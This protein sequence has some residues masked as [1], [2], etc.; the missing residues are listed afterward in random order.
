MKILLIRASIPYMNPI[1]LTASGCSIMRESEQNLVPEHWVSV[2][3]AS[4]TELDIPSNFVCWE[5]E[6]NSNPSVG[7]MRKE[8]K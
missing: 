6:W 3:L 8:D 4:V 7:T 1:A 2:T 5:K